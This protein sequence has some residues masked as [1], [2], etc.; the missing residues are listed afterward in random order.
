MGRQ[1]ALY[2]EIHGLTWDQLLARWRSHEPDE[3]G[4]DDGYL[5]ELAIELR[6][7]VPEG[8]AFLRA[9]LDVPD[10]DRVTAAMLALTLPPL[11]DPSMPRKLLNL[12][13]DERH[14]VRASA[15]RGLDAYEDPTAL[16]LIVPLLNDPS[17]WVR[18]AALEFVR[19][20]DPERGKSALL[21]ALSDSAYLVRMCAADELDELGDSTA[22]PHLKPLLTDPHP[23]V[24]QA[25]ETAVA[26]LATPQRTAV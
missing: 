2:E 25:A 5:D 1:M 9:Q 10:E 14:M 21:S 4:T 8:V 6:Q 7:R 20:H 17:P 13:T 18:C 22:L 11:D 23:Y 15:V 26:N 16:P 24:R 12:L 3:P 19:R